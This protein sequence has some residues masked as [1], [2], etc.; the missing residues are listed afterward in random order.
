VGNNIIG[1]PGVPLHGISTG[2]RSAAFELQDLHVSQILLCL[3]GQR[4]EEY[5]L[6]RSKRFRQ[7]SG[8]VHAAYYMQYLFPAICNLLARHLTV[9]PLW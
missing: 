6:L 8:A 9:V 1:E 2:D 3:A 5:P 7:A 4:S